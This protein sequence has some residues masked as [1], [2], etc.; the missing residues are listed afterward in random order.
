MILTFVDHKDENDLNYIFLPYLPNV[1]MLPYEAQIHLCPSNGIKK[2]VLFA[3][4]S[5]IDGTDVFLT[6]FYV[7]SGNGTVG[8]TWLC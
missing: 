3:W 1:L 5:H 8:N 4:P 2:S 7:L 6:G